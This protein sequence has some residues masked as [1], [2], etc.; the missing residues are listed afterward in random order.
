MNNRPF[1][2]QQVYINVV[3]RLRVIEFTLAALMDARQ[4]TRFGGDS[5]GARARV[6]ILAPEARARANFIAANLARAAGR[7]PPSSPI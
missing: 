1:K 6:H 7:L 2:A 5:R 3:Q 4:S